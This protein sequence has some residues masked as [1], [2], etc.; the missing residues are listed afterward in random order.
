MKKTCWVLLIMALAI[1]CSQETEPGNTAGED[2]I[3]L[4]DGK[5]VHGLRSVGKET[6]PEQGWTIENGVL[7]ARK[8][9]KEDS[10]PGG[11][12]I[13]TETFGDFD[14]R[15]EFKLTPG[16]NGGIKYQVK[17][18]TEDDRTW[19][20]GCEYQI[21]DDEGH[22]VVIKDTDDTRK[23]AS[24]YALFEPKDRPL[25]P[26]GEWNQGRIVLQGKTVQHWLNGE[27]VLEY[28]RGSEAFEQARTASKFDKYPEFGK[29]E[30]GHILIQDHGD[31]V[32]YRDIK[33]KKL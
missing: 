9:G 11:D 16:A 15:F 19:A 26:I 27:V 1:S 31:E 5:A 30:Q 32:H 24:L 20:I 14:L 25:K 13:T 2:W 3:Y 4:F 21:I 10:K 28:E 17:E 23:L 18:Y 22:P 12:I 7:I 33:I 29:H 8:G 6:F